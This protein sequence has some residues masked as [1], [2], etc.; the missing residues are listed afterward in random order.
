MKSSN[1][2]ADL[3]TQLGPYI[4]A[5]DKNRIVRRVAIDIA[6]ATDLVD[7]AD[8]LAGVALDITDD[9]HIR[10]QAASAVS[11]ISAPTAKMR[12]KALVTGPHQEDI[13]DEL[14]GYSL[15]SLWPGSLSVP[16]LLATLTLPKNTSYFGA[17]AFFLLEMEIPPLSASDA[18]AVLDWLANYLKKEQ[19]YTVFDRILPRLLT[20]AL[21][22]SNDDNV[23]ERL[24]DFLV[25]TVRDGTYWSY[26]SELQKIFSESLFSNE[27]SRRALV[28]S[29]I[30]KSTND[31]ER[32]YTALLGGPASLLTK[33]DLVW[34]VGE[35]KPELRE[36]TKRSLINVIVA[37]TFGRNLEDLSFVWDAAE[38]NSDL[39]E[40]LGRAYSV[41]VSSAVAKW[42]REDSEVK[43]RRTAEERELP[44]QF[45]KRIEDDISRLETQRSFDWWKLNLLFLTQKSGRLDGSSEFTSDLTKSNGW[46]LISEFQ[47]E[48]TVLLARRYLVENRVRS[49]PWLGTATFNRPA[50]AGYS[51]LRLLF[52]V[53]HVL[54]LGLDD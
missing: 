15:R 38:N 23:R 49:S 44:T 4:L 36:E 33:D 54:F 1:F 16:E 13:D 24:G 26:S 29:I 39:Y 14:K 5:K 46:A 6:E 34:L 8:I 21:E 31:T 7:L 2:F 43:K 53:A 3:V 10:A 35:L 27:R 50:A 42:Q 52:S 41:D 30:H 47:R 28:L 25:G 19:T 11:R 9:I 20:R 37:Q 40:A 17:Y 45:V 22:A 51:A 12:L 18:I 48:R 32:D